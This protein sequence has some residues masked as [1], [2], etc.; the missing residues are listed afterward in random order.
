MQ[1]AAAALDYVLGRRGEIPTEEDRCV[2]FVDAGASGVQ[3]CV[4][5]MRQDVLQVLSHAHAADAG[6][7]VRGAL[8]P[9]AFDPTWRWDPGVVV[10]V[11]VVVA[12]VV[13][14]VAVTWAPGLMV[15]AEGWERV[16]LGSA[17][18]QVLRS[19]ELWLRLEEAKAL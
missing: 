11:A 13:V 18:G 5:R 6:G 16:A 19:R 7:T 4:V 17:A 9:L 3:F 12:V 10:A 14:V 2:A 15:V 8:R 1:G